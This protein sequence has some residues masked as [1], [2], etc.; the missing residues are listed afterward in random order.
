MNAFE[1]REPRIDLI[2]T[3]ITLDQAGVSFSKS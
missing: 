1:S 3:S 2:I